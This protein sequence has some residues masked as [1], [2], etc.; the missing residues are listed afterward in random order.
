MS[1]EVKISERRERKEKKE[2]LGR[3]WFF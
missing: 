1:E 2:F 3:W